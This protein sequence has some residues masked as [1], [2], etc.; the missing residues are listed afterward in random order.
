MRYLPFNHWPMRS[1]ALSLMDLTPPASPADWAECWESCVLTANYRIFYTFRARSA[2]LLSRAAGGR[3]SGGFGGRRRGKRATAAGA[4][5]HVH[6]AVG[7][8][9][10]IPGV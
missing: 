5:D 8:N 1:A 4:D 9:R 7:R 3:G 2:R 6:S 10:P